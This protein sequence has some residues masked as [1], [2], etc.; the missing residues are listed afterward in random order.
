MFDSVGPRMRALC[1]RK[2]GS[3]SPLKKDALF[4]QDVLHLIDSNPIYSPADVIGTTL[5]FR[6]E[7]MCQRLGS[8]ELSPVGYSHQRHHGGTRV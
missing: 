6:Q 8:F 5:P 4:R 2:Y 7:M 3:K 1:D